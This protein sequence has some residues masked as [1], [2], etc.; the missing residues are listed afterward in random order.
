MDGFAATAE[1]RKREAH[2][3]RTPI[4][5]MT[6]RAMKGDRERCIAAGMDD[7]IAKPVQREKLFAVI[8]R[9]APRADSS[10][11][12][13]PYADD[14]SVSKAL[15]QMHREFGADMLI[16]LIDTFLSDTG[17][18]LASLQEAIARGDSISASREAHGIKGSYRS[19]G[20]QRMAEVCAGLEAQARADS[21]S[22]AQA[23][24]KCLSLN[25]T[26][27]SELLR[28]ERSSY[29]ELSKQQG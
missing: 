18:R 2:G 25:F 9:W 6:A 24:L 11:F 5:A 10:D 12:P 17:N 27:L 19:I 1:I 21:L 29:P 8:S 23:A 3:R 15:K 14:K 22:N 4:V 7:Y 13:G 20:A 28:A 26:H 16:T